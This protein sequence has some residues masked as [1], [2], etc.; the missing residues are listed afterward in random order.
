LVGDN[1]DL[2]PLAIARWFRDLPAYVDRGD[3]TSPAYFG[4]LSAARNHDPSRGVPFRVY[5]LAR[6]RGAVRDG[7]RHMDTVPRK[8]RQAITSA[9]R[10]EVLLA[11]TLGRT[12]THDEVVSMLGM[13]TDRLFYI[14][15]RIADSLQV[16]GKTHPREY[17][18]CI[19][20]LLEAVG[21][22]SPETELDVSN[23]VAQLGPLEHAVVVLRYYR[24]WTGEEIGELLG[25]T[26][27]RVSQI[28][29]VA[30][31]KLGLMLGQDSP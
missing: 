27:Q 17:P 25:V 13:D 11:Q 19:V 31:K 10:A 15:D 22:M 8:T 4:L 3:L 28:N 2:I 9:R 24:G 23:A 21:A 12:P 29:G 26:A 16:A 14:Q 5:A 7:L 6:I 20:S 30:L 1:L 18:D